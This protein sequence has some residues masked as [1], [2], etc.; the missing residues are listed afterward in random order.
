MAYGMNKDHFKTLQGRSSHGV[1]PVIF[2]MLVNIALAFFKITV[3]IIGTSYAL[4]A[5]GIES[6]A[7]VFTSFVV[8]TGTRVGALPPDAN[9]PYGHGKAES[10][11]AF[12]VS[13]ILIFSAGIIAYK[14]IQEIVT[15]QHSPAFYTLIA[16]ILVVL[17][18]EGMYH[19]L[20]RAALET[21]LSTLTAD[22]WHHRSDAM[23]SM[24]A[25]VG[26]LIALIGGE[27]FAAA[28][29]W[30]A[31]FASGII[32]WNARGILKGAVGEIMDESVPE[33]LVEKIRACCKKMEDVFDVE[34]CR[35]RRS[36][37]GYFVDLHIEVDG[38][39]TVKQGHD[40]AH[41]VKGDLFKADLNIIDVIIHVEPVPA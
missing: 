33:D 39:L 30:A 2:G 15:P 13:L 29:D 1:R 8:I 27:K 10:L 4:V 36:G 24:A 20:K 9:H 6:V 26:I 40:I 14:S 41:K 19:R 31:L 22:A 5:D 18:K 16:L 25:F 37:L 3:G 38:N 21:G 12:T 28:D 23:T 7:D 34:T 32:F 11:A 17:V 35:A